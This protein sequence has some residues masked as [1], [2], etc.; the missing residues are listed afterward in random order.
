MQTSAI[1]LVGVFTEL[2]NVMS[3]SLTKEQ[4]LHILDDINMCIPPE[5]FCVHCM[6][7]RAILKA[8]IREN[9]DGLKATEKTSQKP[10]PSRARKTPTKSAKA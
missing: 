8:K 9:I 10:K 6:K 2:D 3:S 1:D 5:Q 4:K 7:T